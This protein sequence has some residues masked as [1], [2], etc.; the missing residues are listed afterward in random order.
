MANPGVA[1]GNVGAKESAPNEIRVGQKRAEAYVRI[2]EQLFLSYEE[3]ILCGLGNSESFF[4][5]FSVF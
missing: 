5:L 2:S 4:R 1:V 3:I